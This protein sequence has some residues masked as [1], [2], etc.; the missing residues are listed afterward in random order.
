MRKDIERRLGKLE[1]TAAPGRMICA[2]DTADNRAL[3]HCG[4]MPDPLGAPP[5][6]HIR[7]RKKLEKWLDGHERLRK[8]D[9]VVFLIEAEMGL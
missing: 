2:L 3:V 9:T 1:T 7:N 5:A 4:L 6:P 8:N